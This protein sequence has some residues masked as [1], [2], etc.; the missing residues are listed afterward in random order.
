[1]IISN[2]TVARPPSLRAQ[3]LAREA[4]GLSGAPLFE[5]STHMLAET[6]R[7]VAGRFPLVGV[8]GIDSP[9]RARAKL[10][11]GATLVQLYS[12]LVFEGP[13]LVEAIKRG[14][15]HSG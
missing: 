8:G 6:A 13:G 1:M 11:A 3:T 12:G 14:L 4:G 9:E 15:R 5:P 10:A 7:R 2:T